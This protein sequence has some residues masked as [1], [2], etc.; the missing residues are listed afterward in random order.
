MNIQIL[1]YENMTALDAIGPYECL[2]RIPG[3]KLTMVGLHKGMV[4]TDTGMLGLMVDESVSDAPLADVILVPGGPERGIQ[5]MIASPQ[6]K[7]WLT[8]QH[9][10][11]NVTASVCTGSLILIAH[12]I[13]TS[14][15]VAS[16][17]AAKPVIESMGVSYSGQRITQ[18]GKVMTA[19]GVSA[20]IDMALALIA[21]LTNQ[22]TAKMIQLGIEYDPKPPFTMQATD[23]RK[24][25]YMALSKQIGENRQ[26]GC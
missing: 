21:T 25:S 1:L 9:A 14:G 16:H 2:S 23:A 3:V 12:G 4:R 6:I 11:S 24:T 20:G 8:R 22:E 5:K 15:A 18:N 17:W 26:V 19:A 7:D 13:I 10:Q